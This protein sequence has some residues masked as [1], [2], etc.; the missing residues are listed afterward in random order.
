M[1]QG[2][3]PLPAPHKQVAVMS[4]L[5]PVPSRRPRATGRAA[6]GQPRRRR[7]RPPGQT[8]TTAQ[9]PAHLSAR[10]PAS[11]LA[12]EAG[13]GRLERD[14]LGA[15][16]GRPLGPAFARCYRN[17]RRGPLAPAPRRRSAGGWRGR[18]SRESCGGGGGGRAE[19][20]GA[21]R[22]WGGRRGELIPGAGGERRAEPSR[23]ERGRRQPP[24]QL[25][26][27]SCERQRRAG[28]GWTGA[29]RRPPPSRPR[30]RVRG[31]AVPL[32]EGVVCVGGCAWRGAAPSPG[33][34][35]PPAR[36]PAPPPRS[37]RGRGLATRAKVVRRAPRRR[38][39][40]SARSPAPPPGG[41]SSAPGRARVPPERAEPGA[42]FPICV[43][44]SSGK[45]APSGSSAPGAPAGGRPAG[46]PEAAVSGGGPLRSVQ[47]RSAPRRRRLPALPVPGGGGRR[48]GRPAEGP[49]GGGGTTLPCGP[50]SGT[51]PAFEVQ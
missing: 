21:A 42:I 30:S 37:W 47:C 46:R 51:L 50:G 20:S 14:E 33:A 32:T 13:R 43:F 39:R 45:A 36:Q 6:A 38:R 19:R 48:R 4:D 29:A 27:V 31:A 23:A 28:V 40:L 2:V 18:L 10:A 17:A 9:L 12:G 22:S 16:L 7:R 11:K 24:R 34:A 15:G 35:R 8:P 25:C 1:L 41:G 44:F 3:Q 5:G 26:W 49:G